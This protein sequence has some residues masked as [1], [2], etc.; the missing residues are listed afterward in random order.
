MSWKDGK[1]V[2]GTTSNHFG[3]LHGFIASAQKY[4][5]ISWKIVV[6]DLIGDLTIS[7]INSISSWCGVEYRRF[8]PNRTHT[9]WNSKYV[10][11]SV[12]KPIIIFDALHE[13]PR[14]GI[15]FYGDTSTRL[16]SHFTTR[17]LNAVENIGFV[18]RMTS[19]PVSL[20][21]HPTTIAELTRN[22][23]Y[24][25][26][27]YINAPMI[28]GCI[29]FWAKK[30]DVIENILKPFMKCTSTKSCILPD[31]ADGQENEIGL[32]KKCRPGKDGHCH[33][34][35][36]SALSVI[37][38]DKFNVQ[39]GETPPYLR[40]TKASEETYRMCRANLYGTSITTERASQKGSPKF[41]S[42]RKC[43]RDQVH[44]L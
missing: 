37:L 25:K 12:W 40:G 39:T 31:G 2:T 20:Y 15:V 26:T 7:N 3:Q 28:C 9:T 35:D 27:R 22:I 6:Y 4:L 1:L 23:N 13:L 21:T 41:Q 38:Y 32:S 14:N 36:Q 43:K 5:P 11:L 17:L 24:N 16:Q 42:D 30:K 19:S 8:N 44:S 18:G 34:G 29:Q 33:R 10:T